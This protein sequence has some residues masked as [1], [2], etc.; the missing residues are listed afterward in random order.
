MKA[1]ELERIHCG[2][3]GRETAEHRFKKSREGEYWGWK[4]LAGRGEGWVKQGC[5]G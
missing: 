5:K 3:K 1:R 2:S 4:G